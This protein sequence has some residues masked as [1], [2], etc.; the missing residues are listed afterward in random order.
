MKL[1]EAINSGLI[2]DRPAFGIAGRLY[3]ATNESIL[4]RDTG[5]EW[6][7]LTTAGS[8]DATSIQ[9]ITVASGVPTDEQVLA[10]NSSTEEWEPTT[11]SGVGGGIDSNTGVIGDIPAAG[12]DGNIYLPSDSLIVAR[13]NGST[14]DYWGPIFKVTRPD[15]TGYSWVNQVDAT[16]TEER[17]GYY[18]QD[19]A[20]A[21]IDVHLYAKTIPTADNYTL[22]IGFLHSV[23]PANYAQFGLMV[24]ESSSSKFIAMTL[25]ARS[26]IL[27]YSV[28][29]FTNTST[30]SADYSTTTHAPI[31]SPMLFIRVRDNGTTRYYE[32]SVDG[33][34]WFTIYSHGRTT[35]ITPDQYGIIVASY[36]SSYTVGGTI[37]HKVEA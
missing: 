34:H 33:S 24:R 5:T 1:S 14:W 7:S 8:G 36:Q 32:Y 6:E 35:F 3:Y 22:S 16:I 12:N 19:P 4:Y 15:W 23:I 18:I 37:L 10:Y 28:C 31:G 17:G 11:I 13:D 26:A 27:T 21:G 9:G 30:W 20:N 2:G 25:E 29:A